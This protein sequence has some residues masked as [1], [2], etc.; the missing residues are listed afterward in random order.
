MLKITRNIKHCAK[1]CSTNVTLL[2]LNFAAQNFVN[3]SNSRR[4]QLQV[5]RSPLQVFGSLRTHPQFNEK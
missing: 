3:L 1:N 5:R 2:L 4:S